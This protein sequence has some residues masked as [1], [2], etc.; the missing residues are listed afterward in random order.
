MHPMPCTPPKDAASS[1]THSS[2]QKVGSNTKNASTCGRIAVKA[3]N[4]GPSTKDNPKITPDNHASHLASGDRPSGNPLEP[5]RGLTTAGL[6]VGNMMRWKLPNRGQALKSHMQK[7]YAI[8]CEFPISQ[9]MTLRENE[10]LPDRAGLVYQNVAGHLL[11][12][13]S[14]Q[15]QPGVIIP[16]EDRHPYVCRAHEAC[17]ASA[18]MYSWISVPSLETGAITWKMSTSLDLEMLDD[19]RGVRFTAA[20]QRLQD[21]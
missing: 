5:R 10:S 4:A 13:A 16:V 8:T 12:E 3:V 15:R 1:M 18:P 6:D 9:A 21:A 14:L 11:G 17:Y 2:E 19:R 7:I 20:Y